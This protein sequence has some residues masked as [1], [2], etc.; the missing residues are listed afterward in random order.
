MRGQVSA[1]HTLRA[2]PK[3]EPTIPTRD[4]AFSATKWSATKNAAYVPGH[5]T[6]KGPELG[7]DRPDINLKGLQRL[8]TCCSYVIE[9]RL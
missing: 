4:W 8:D 9:F 7:H 2:L 1:N 6:L 5:I 3:P